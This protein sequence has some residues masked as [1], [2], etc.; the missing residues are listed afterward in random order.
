MLKTESRMIKPRK[1]AGNVWNYDAADDRPQAVVTPVLGKL[2]ALVP[3][4]LGCTQRE[5]KKVR[6]QQ[7]H[8]TNF[9]TSN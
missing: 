5:A 7:Q 6:K 9:H 3:Q 2:Q 1:F 8:E 4:S